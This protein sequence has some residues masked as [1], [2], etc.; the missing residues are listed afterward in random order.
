MMSVPIAKIKIEQVASVPST[1]IQQCSQ[2]SYAAMP[3]QQQKGSTL[4]HFIQ[5][6]QFHTREFAH[7]IKRANFGCMLQLRG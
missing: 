4:V 1:A 2:H 3:S 5:A 6:R 7:Y